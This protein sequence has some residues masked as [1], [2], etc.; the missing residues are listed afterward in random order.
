MLKIDGET[1]FCK[2]QTVKYRYKE[3][4]SRQHYM[5]RLKDDKM[6]VDGD[7]GLR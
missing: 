1:D 6:E 2:I 5:K 7:I 3:K 4:V